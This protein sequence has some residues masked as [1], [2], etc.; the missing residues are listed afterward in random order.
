[1]FCKHCGKNIYDLE[2]CPF[3]NDGEKVE[4]EN[5]EPQSFNSTD[6]KMELEAIPKE[7]TA[8][9]KNKDDENTAEVK[10]ISFFEQLCEKN[11]FFKFLNSSKKPLD[12]FYV[13]GALL[14]V[15]IMIMSVIKEIDIPI[16]LI[17]EIGKVVI[18]VT[19][20]APIIVSVL[21]TIIF[22]SQMKKKMPSNELLFKGVCPQG[23]FEYSSSNINKI[24]WQGISFKYNKASFVLSVFDYIFDC[25]NHILFYV[26]FF[27]PVLNA[28]FETFGPYLRNNIISTLFAY[29]K[30]VV[31]TKENLG[32][33]ITIIALIIARTVMDIVQTKMHKKLAKAY[34]ANELK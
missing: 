4:I 32:I 11:K 16:E 24:T 18:Y 9:E 33:I 17:G 25:T 13:F 2:K 1:M 7:E 23:E 31:F 12:I 22:I 5:D 8:T 19:F 20:F 15:F 34:Q 6:D 3:C 30:G 21:M 29:C 27:R 14:L 10:K 28:N 26:L